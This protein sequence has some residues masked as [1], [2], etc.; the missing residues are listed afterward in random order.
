MRKT[1]LFITG[2]LLLFSVEGQILR[3]SNYTALPPPPAEGYTTQYDAILAAWTN[4]PTGDTLEW[5]DNMVYSLD[6]AGYWDRIKL[7]YV[8]ANGRN[9]NAK[10][11][12]V[13]PGTYNLTDPGSTNPTFTAYQGFDGDGSSD[14]LSTGWLP[15]TDSTGVGVNDITLASWQLTSINNLEITMGARATDPIV[16]NLRLYPKYEDNLQGHVVS[17]NAQSFGSVTSSVGFSMITR[18]TGNLSE[19]YY[20]GASEGTNSDASATNLPNS[21]FYVLAFNLADGTP[22]YPFTGI[23]SIALVMDAVTDTDAT[24]IYNIIHHYMTHIGQ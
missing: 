22:Y 23:L 2:L 9:A 10:I 15:A 13:S 1:I 8:M 3:Y 11:N 20:N 12:W 19:G 17:E 18:T 24:N 14:Y 5:Q 16:S 6:S 21:T 7:F 4:D